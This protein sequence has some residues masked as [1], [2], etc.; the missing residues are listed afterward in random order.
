[1]KRFRG[2]PFWFGL[3][4]ILLFPVGVVAQ[5]A[6]KPD[7]ATAMNEAKKEGKDVLIFV[8]GT[9]WSKKS[10]DYRDK[11]LSSSPLSTAFGSK[12][13]F[14]EIDKP[15]WPTEEQ[16]KASENN[17]GFKSLPRVFP[18]VAVLDSEGLAWFSAGN[19]SGSP[20][21]LI[22]RIGSAQTIK[23]ERDKLL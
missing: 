22:K 6:W 14:V 23:A 21:E 17:K 19:L 4:L 5:I 13:L 18:G 11:L 10:R 7:F 20:E 9:D 8:T 16:K 15:D 2:S 3:V 12:F 1:M